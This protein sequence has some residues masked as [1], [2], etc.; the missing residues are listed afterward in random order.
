MGC[1]LRLVKAHA[2]GSAHPPGKVGVSRGRFEV[3][4]WRW[5]ASRRVDLAGRGR[6]S[7]ACCV[8]AG[9][10]RLFFSRRLHPARSCFLRRCYSCPALGLSISIT[11]VDV[12]L[13]L[14]FTSVGTCLAAF[15]LCE[16]VFRL[17]APARGG[18]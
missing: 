8:F 5:A 9:R 16:K 13:Q 3:E 10:V 7:N 14:F 2:G 1:W 17:L 6:E 15:S 4:G 12:L 11:A 18:G